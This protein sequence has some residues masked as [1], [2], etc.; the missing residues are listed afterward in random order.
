MSLLRSWIDSANNA[1]T[2]FPLNNLPYGV[3]SVGD[4]D[5]R[6]GV[7]IGDRV[8]D[9]TGLEAAGILRADADA[10]V[11]DAPFWNDFMALGPG[12][13]SVY[14]A[15]LQALLA[16]GADDALQDRVIAY[17]VPLAEADLHMPFQVS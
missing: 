9:A 4:S 15:A 6:C 3:F 17:T 10:D 16:E 14:R 13:W 8:L 2:P 11:L 1:E 12:A 7:A 5:L